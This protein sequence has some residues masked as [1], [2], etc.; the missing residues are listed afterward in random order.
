[1]ARNIRTTKTLARRMDLQYFARKHP[2]R[3]WRFYLSVLVPVI[4]VAWFLSSRATGQKVYSSGPLS[5]AH[6]V[7]GKQCQVCH[8]TERG[9]FRTEV[10][11][12]ACLSC[13]DAPAH[14][15]SKV[16]FTPACGSCHVEHKGPVKLAHT[17][18][19]TC[20]QCHTNLR[21]KTGQLR[22]F[23]S[24][25]GFDGARHPEFVELKPGF[26]PGTVKLNHFAHLKKNLAGP[27]GPVQLTCQD[28]HRLTGEEGAWP[29]ALGGMKTVSASEKDAMP[30]TEG[31]ISREVLPHA[32]M[33]PIRYATQ[34][35]ACHTKDLQFDKR[36]NESVPHDKPEVVQAF[37]VKKYTDY[38]ATHPNA[39]SEPLPPNRILS[40]NI[41]PPM[42]PPPH[43]RE[44][45]INWQVTYADRLLFDKGCKL[46]HTMIEREGAVPSVA[47][48]S[49]PPIPAVAK[50]SIPVRWLNHA[51]FDHDA[52]RLL[53]CTACHGDAPT[54]KLT[55]DILLPKIKACQACHRESGAEHD[56]ANARCSDCHQYHDWRKEQFPKHNYT[57]QQLRGTVG[58]M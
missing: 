28:C 4:A 13:H 50:S 23:E 10:K 21:V 12:T 3:S 48:Y 6:A 54:S 9:A 36:F 18:S 34:C 2:L 19:S 53:T 16:E 30:T 32:Y 51:D 20:T 11:D 52:H 27:N 7:F 33:S 44:E 17:A 24:V 43:T 58:G 35:A 57:I 40:G 29:Y 15:P 55:S 41:L 5:S 42:P 26:D 45:W 46:C 14:H 31:S 38:F 49:I 47:T 56:A 39:L 1:M 8:V 25:R 37:L 22:Y